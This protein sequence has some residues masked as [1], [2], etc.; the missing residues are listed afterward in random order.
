[1]AGTLAVINQLRSW[2]VGRRVL[3]VNDVRYTTATVNAFVFLVAWGSSHHSAPGTETCSAK[4]PL[5][6]RPS[7]LLHLPCQLYKKH[8]GLSNGCH[9]KYDISARS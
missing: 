8:E 9:R 7:G 3:D 4:L 6:C 5:R 1:M 2:E